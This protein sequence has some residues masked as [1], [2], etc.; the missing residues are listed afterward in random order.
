MSLGLICILAALQFTEKPVKWDSYTGYWDAFD[1]RTS[2]W[3][4]TAE[5]YVKNDKMNARVVKLPEYAPVKIC[6][7]CSPPLKNQ[8]LLGMDIIWDL[9]ED[10]GSLV[11]GKILD[12]SSGKIYD[13]AISPGSSETL[14]VR[15]YFKLKTFGKTQI[16]RKS[17]N[18]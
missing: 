9:E 13:C 11:H 1:D 2:Q 7:L 4:F 6:E 15:G 17:K 8:A 3:S 12:P 16:W 18:K 10:H 5:L 14:K